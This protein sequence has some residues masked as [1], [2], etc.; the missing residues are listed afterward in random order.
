MLRENASLEVRQR[1]YEERENEWKRKD[2]REF[3]AAVKTKIS[4]CQRRFTGIVY[5]GNEADF[6]DLDEIE[7]WFEEELTKKELR[8]TI[9]GAIKQT[10][11]ST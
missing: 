9:L 7:A 4:E 1:R 3:R 6:S 10:K 5:T 2:E 11:R 8:K